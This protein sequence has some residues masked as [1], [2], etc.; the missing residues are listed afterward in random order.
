MTLQSS[1]EG[2]DSRED[3][4]GWC[5]F[6]C[7]LHAFDSG[8]SK[9]LE[10]FIECNAMSYVLSIFE[11]NS[12]FWCELR[13]TWNLDQQSG[14]QSPSSNK[15]DHTALQEIEDLLAQQDERISER[16]SEIVV[17]HG[18]MRKL[19]EFGPTDSAPYVEFPSQLEAGETNP[20]KFHTVICQ[21]APQ[22]QKKVLAPELRL[23]Q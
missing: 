20:R 4:Q 6:V 10:K 23:D 16:A 8:Q 12:T 7:K 18:A 17:S 21:P 13:A 19:T 11:P 5:K 2:G 22:W 14:P 1:V 15:L 3:Q 9:R